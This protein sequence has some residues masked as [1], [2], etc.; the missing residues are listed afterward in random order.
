[1]EFESNYFPKEDIRDGYY[2]NLQS[3][4]LKNK[5]GI[6]YISPHILIFDDRKFRCRNIHHEIAH[7]ILGHKDI[8]SEEELER[9][10]D[11]AYEKADEWWR[12][13]F[14]EFS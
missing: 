1:M 7:H 9:Q 4:D 6:I 3:E 11:A 14:G 2:M 8:K 10:E 13:Y 12:E 5:K